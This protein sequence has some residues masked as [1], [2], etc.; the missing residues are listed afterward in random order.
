MG[1]A[2]EYLFHTI[3]CYYINLKHDNVWFVGKESKSW[4]GA[5]VIQ[6]RWHL[7][8]ASWIVNQRPLC[9]FGVKLLLPHYTIPW[10]YPMTNVKSVSKQ[11]LKALAGCVMRIKHQEKIITII[12]K[13]V[14]AFNLA[15]SAYIHFYSTD[16]V[17]NYYC[18]IR[19][20]VRIRNS[21]QN[22]NMNHILA[23]SIRQSL[24]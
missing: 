12:V 19:I 17:H 16:I 4:T 3:F 23:K 15:Y 20:N 2:V 10:A 1:D 21:W 6:S 9:I 14:K 22:V 7:T 5:F 13:H 18:P 8:F 11:K 24:R